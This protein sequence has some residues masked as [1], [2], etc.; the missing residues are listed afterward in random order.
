MRCWLLWLLGECM[1]DVL[2]MLISLLF[3]EKIGVVLYV[4]VVNVV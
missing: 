1:V 3:G 2:S 4:S